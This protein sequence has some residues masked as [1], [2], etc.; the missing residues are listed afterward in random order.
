MAKNNDGSSINEKNQSMIRLDIY[1]KRHPSLS[2]TEFHEFVD[3]VLVIDKYPLT[4]ECRRW[5]KV[6]GSLVK[7]WLAEKGIYRYTQVWTHLYIRLCLPI[8]FRFYIP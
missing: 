3:D 6:H 2:S 1:V 8:T 7:G 4:I 5:S